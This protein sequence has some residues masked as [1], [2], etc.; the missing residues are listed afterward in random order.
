MCVAFSPDGKRLAAGLG[1]TVTLWDVPGLPG[2]KAGEQAFVSAAG[3]EE[4]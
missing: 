1:E 4:G 2:R 3:V